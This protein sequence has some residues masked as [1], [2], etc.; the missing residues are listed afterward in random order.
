MV[1]LR[2]SYRH[3]IDSRTFVLYG[4]LMPTRRLAPLNRAVRGVMATICGSLTLS[5]HCVTL[6]QSNGRNG[7]V[8][9]RSS[10][11]QRRLVG[12]SLFCG[13]TEKLGRNALDRAMTQFLSTIYDIV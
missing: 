5:Y 2:L 7:R 8:Y 12:D 11:V 3:A 9:G 4:N 6:H 13:A 10:A 1:V